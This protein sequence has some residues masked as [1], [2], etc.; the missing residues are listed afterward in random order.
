M[1]DRIGHASIP[2]VLTLKVTASNNGEVKKQTLVSRV[3]GPLLSPSH[4]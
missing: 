2:K 4:W 3:Q 1:R